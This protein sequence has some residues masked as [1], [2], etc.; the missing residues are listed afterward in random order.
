MGTIL[1]FEIFNIKLID[2]LIAL[3]IIIAIFKIIG[4]LGNRKG[5]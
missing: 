4:I 3:A 1:N 5:D 2:Y